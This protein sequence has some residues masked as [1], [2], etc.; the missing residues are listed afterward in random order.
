MMNV[1]NKSLRI[2]ILVFFVL[3]GSFASCKQAEPTN[4]VK[5]SFQERKIKLPDEIGS[6]FDLCESGNKLLISAFDQTGKVGWLW[7]S[8]D[9]GETWMKRSTFTDLISR[10][11]TAESESDYEYSAY[12]SKMGEIFLVSQNWLSDDTLIEEYFLI[13]GLESRT[14][15]LVL[16][17]KNEI[18]NG[19]YHA[20]FSDD[21]ELF[22]EDL[23]GQLYRIDKETGTILNAY[24]PE[25]TALLTN[26]FAVS[27]GDLYVLTDD[28]LLT[29]S[30]QNGAQSEKTATI[31]KILSEI[32][33]DEGFERIASRKINVSNT[34]DGPEITYIDTSGIFRFSSDGSSEKLIDGSDTCMY[35]GGVAL[36]DF[37]RADEKF[38][39][40]VQDQT[41]SALYRYEKPSESTGDDEKAE[42]T[43]YTLKANEDFETLIK[44][45]RESN[46]NVKIT[47]ITG[48]TED[49]DISVSDALKL[50]NTDILA[51]RGPDIICFD[52]IDESAFIE[53][54]LLLNL[55]QTISDLEQTENLF[56]NILNA[57]KSGDG[58][59]VVP[60]KFSFACIAGPA[61]LVE[62][63]GD[64]DALNAKLVQMYTQ[65]NRPPVFDEL[66]FNK[67]VRIFYQ[68]YLSAAT[69]ENDIPARTQ[70][71]SFYN[72]IK[73]LYNICD[74]EDAWRKDERAEK[75]ALMP[76][77][78]QEAF[79]VMAGLN[80]ISIQ[81]VMGVRDMQALYT[82]KEKEGLSYGTWELEGKNLFVGQN[83][84][85]I[86]A[87]SE[88]QDE[89]R[90]VLAFLFGEDAQNRVRPFAWEDGFP[91][92][93]DVLSEQFEHS[94]ASGPT[95]TNQYGEDIHIE[96]TPFTAEDVVEIFSFLDHLNTPIRNNLL[97]YEIVT[98]PLGAY[99]ND[100]ISLKEIVN[101]TENK[102]DIY[103]KE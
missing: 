57:Y 35:G 17:T 3:V 25:D 55:S 49:T 44:L 61:E 5:D 15:P 27:D 76:Y 8:E 99:L 95:L 64:L 70:L 63:R 84:I 75:E 89:S 42:L 23:W 74:D 101:I 56:M 90:K 14:V 33:T 9:A 98:E 77:S 69:G 88:H 93:K 39:L 53:K 20:V 46:P 19:I 30:V 68:T 97:L 26:D 100:D 72:A 65:N 79:C 62:V 6:V 81:D 66:I 85:G 41:G 67:I 24:L 96:Y 52:N 60:T 87:K 43:L 94:E 71:E 51:G 2:F 22:A 34:E 102:L 13:N 83:V 50:L 4:I 78:Y 91:V 36:Y 18:S 11:S 82:I 59:Y 1:K 12:L 54:G 21:G 86:N 31:D 40:I 47:L 58:L 73:S 29:Y 16:P 32:E 38:F 28:D 7:E 48:I 103:T 10:D 45:Y 37:E 80:Q 92:N